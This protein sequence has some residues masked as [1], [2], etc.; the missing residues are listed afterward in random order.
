MRGGGL[1]L[2]GI[3]RPLPVEGDGVHQ[4]IRGRGGKRREG[5]SCDRDVRSTKRRYAPMSTLGTIR[6]LLERIASIARASSSLRTW[7]LE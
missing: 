1:K 2:R 3:L 4:K 6:V 7:D 5:H